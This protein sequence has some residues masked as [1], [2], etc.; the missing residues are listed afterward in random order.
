MTVGS[1]SNDVSYLTMVSWWRPPVLL[2][3][4]LLEGTSFIVPWYHDTEGTGNPEHHYMVISFSLYH[5]VMGGSDFDF[6]I[7]C[8]LVL[9]HF[10]R[11]T[12]VQ[13]QNIAIHFYCLPS[14]DNK[15]TLIV[16]VLVIG[17]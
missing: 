5:V 16:E 10:E 13:I 12:R 3:R 15:C 2:S 4:M 7:P 9:C 14:L 11:R 8:S 6:D 1:S 17:Y